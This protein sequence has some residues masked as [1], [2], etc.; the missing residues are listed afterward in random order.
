MQPVVEHPF[1]PDCNRRDFTDE[2]SRSGRILMIARIQ[3]SSKLIRCSQID[4]NIFN[5]EPKF[6]TAFNTVTMLERADDRCAALVIQFA[7]GKGVHPLDFLNWLRS[8]TKLN[9]SFEQACSSISLLHLQFPLD[10]QGKK[11]GNVKLHDAYLQYEKE[12]HTGIIAQSTFTFKTGQA[13]LEF[14]QIR[15]HGPLTT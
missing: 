12:K 13:C 15:T 4:E 11:L 5:D 2:A 10:E 6:W 1:E 3:G 8:E 14:K 9:L 7:K